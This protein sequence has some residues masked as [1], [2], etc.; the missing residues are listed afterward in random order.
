MSLKKDNQG[1]LTKEISNEVV[2]G[3]QKG[4]AIM[5]LS[6][7]E[8]MKTG[9]KVIPVLDG[10]NA[11]VVG[12][13][14]KIGTADAGFKPVTLKTKKH[15]IIV[16]FSSELVNESIVDVFE[17]IKDD[18]NE[19]FAR[20]FDKNAISNIVTA[21]A[22]NTVTEGATEGQNF[23]EDL[24]DAMAL[25]EAKGFDVNGF[26]TGHATKNRFRKLKDANGNSLYVPAI[27][28]AMA[29]E[30]Y[31]QPVAYSFGLDADTTAVMGDFRYSVVGVQGDIQY[32]LLEEA[33][34]NGVN[35]AEQDMVALRVIANFAHVVTREDAFSALK[36]A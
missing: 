33:T 31:G 30:L 34:V 4:S 11:Y 7:I 5:Q 3:V 24:S 27:T 18:I 2:K 6:K 10:L 25:A 9:E 36:N 14:E 8:P 26:V 19:Q 12:E 22:G 16:P 20:L 21:V 13:G 23:A 28:D 17:E 1:V 35:L 15:A 29:D 32:K